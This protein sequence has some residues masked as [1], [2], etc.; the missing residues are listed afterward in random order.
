MVTA[1]LANYQT[2]TV[3]AT[4][5]TRA[6]DC[7]SQLLDNW[8]EGSLPKSRANSFYM[9]NGLCWL[10]VVSSKVTLNLKTLDKTA[11][12]AYTVEGC[13]GNGIKVMSYKDRFC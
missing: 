3:N 7:G 4:K 11:N 12:A 2:L 8:R 9:K 6:V 1:V 13:V 5:A 10:G